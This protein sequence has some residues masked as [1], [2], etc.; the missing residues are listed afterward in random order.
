MNIQLLPNRIEISA[1]F[2]QFPAGQGGTSGPA[3][4][5]H[6]YSDDGR[7]AGG[8]ITRSDMLILSEM[9]WVTMMTVFFSFRIMR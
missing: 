2:R 6:G 7:A 4:K 5:F 1:E 8:M 9:S 3:K